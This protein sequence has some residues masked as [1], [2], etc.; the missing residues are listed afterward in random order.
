MIANSVVFLAQTARNLGVK[1]NDQ[2]SFIAN[3]AVTTRSC[4]L[5]LHN[6]RRIRPFLT[7]EVAQVLDIS[8]LDYYSQL[9]CLH[10]SS[11]HCSS[12]R[13]QLPSWSSTYQLLWCYIA[14]P[15]PVLATG[16]CW[17]PIQNSSTC[18]PCCEWLWPILHPGH[19]QTIHPS[20]STMLCCC[21][22]ACYSL[23]QGG[24]TYCSTKLHLFAVLASQWWTELPT[25]IRTSET[26]HIFH[27][28]LKT[29]LIDVLMLM[30]LAI[31]VSTRLNALI[32]SRF[33]QKCQI[34]KYNVM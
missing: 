27:H 31:F 33:G 34:N 12:S 21:Q 11:D 23:T 19:G 5:I 25:D 10:V 8:C 7:Q 17:N 16:G 29:H 18:L 15:F 6:I 4:R 32:V 14:P 24:P 1:V 20:P 26:P 3:I 2:L 9:M 22:T 28:R 13:M 30:I